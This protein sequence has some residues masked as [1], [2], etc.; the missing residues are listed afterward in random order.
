MIFKSSTAKTQIDNFLIRE[1]NTRMCKNCKVIRNEYFGTQHRLLVMDVEIK[2][3][4]RKK[5]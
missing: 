3:S 2:S 5:W 4:E 1:D